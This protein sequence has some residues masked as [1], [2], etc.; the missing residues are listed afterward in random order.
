MSTRSSTSSEVQEVYGRARQIAHDTGKVK[1]LFTTVFGVWMAAYSSGNCEVSLSY[2]S[3]LMSIAQNQSDPGILL[4]AHH[5]AWPMEF[6]IGNF[7]AAHK[8]IE[9]GLPLYD[10]EAHRDHPLLYVGHDPE[11]VRLRLRA[12]VLQAL[13]QPD[14]AL[15]QLDKGLALAREAAHPPSLIHVFG[16]AA[17]YV[18]SPR[19]DED[20]VPRR[21]VALADLGLR[22]RGR[23]RQRDDGPRLGGDHDG[24]PQDRPRRVARWA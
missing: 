4:Q 16:I 3:E 2:T 13:G 24:E 8:H 12:L 6:Y 15:A 23:R 5:C 11:F 7:E 21:R 10:K 9:A 17:T 22:L 20:H 1:E 19:P 14:R 18:F